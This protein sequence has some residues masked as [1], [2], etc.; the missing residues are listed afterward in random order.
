MCTF[1]MA[2]LPDLF[3]TLLVP[4]RIKH[5][6]GTQVTLT[7]SLRLEVQFS[8]GCDYLN[9]QVSSLRCTLR[10]FNFEADSEKTKCCKK[11]TLIHSVK[12]SLESLFSF[13]ISNIVT[14]QRRHPG[15][16]CIFA[17]QPWVVYYMSGSTTGE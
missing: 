9:V 6:A 13:Y 2:G 5:Q 16:C 11:D 15:L 10:C 8:G 14:C 4:P 3:F 7:Y 12:N 17:T 1:R